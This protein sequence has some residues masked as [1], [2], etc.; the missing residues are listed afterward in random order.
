MCFVVQSAEVVCC[1]AN[2]S[3]DRLPSLPSTSGNHT[4]N[5]MALRLILVVIF[6]G[7]GWNVSWWDD[8]H[9]WVEFQAFWHTQISLCVC[10]GGGGLSGPKCTPRNNLKCA[11]GKPFGRLVPIWGLSSSGML[12]AA[13]VCTWVAVTSQKSEDLDYTTA[14]AWNLAYCRHATKSVNRIS[15]PPRCVLSY[16]WCL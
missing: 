15:V 14:G 1:S 3:Q 5:T 13:W 8:W 2:T 12:Y 11:Y 10:W 9:G 7:F 16:A 6:L 4:S